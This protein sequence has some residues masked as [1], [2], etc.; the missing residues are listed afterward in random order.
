MRRIAGSLARSLA[1]LA[2]VVA[3]GCSGS[4][5]EGAKTATVQ[6][7]ELPAIY[8]DILDARDRAHK[9]IAKGTDMWHEDC[10]EVSAATGQLETLL[11]EVQQRASQMPELGTAITGLESHIG[12]TLGVVTMMRENA[13]QEVVGML[14]GNMIQLDAFLRGLETHFTPEQ[15]GGKSVTTRPGFNPN[16]PPP[17]PSPI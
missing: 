12:L 1:V 4:G 5:E 17:P 10:A 14:P 16:P 7:R 8:S 15:I 9:A 6:A 11:T 2:L 3:T 13:V